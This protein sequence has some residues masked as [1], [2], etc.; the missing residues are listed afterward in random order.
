MLFINSAFKS[1]PG[2]SPCF[3][4]IH[5]TND[6]GFVFI[7]QFSFFGFIFNYMIFI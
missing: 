4:F 5:L 2:I 7:C 3:C 6:N 1:N